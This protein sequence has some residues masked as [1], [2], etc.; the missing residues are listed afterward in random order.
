MYGPLVGAGAPPVPSGCN[1][2]VRPAVRWVGGC[3]GHQSVWA[4]IQSAKG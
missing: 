2:K 1:G 3:R 4:V